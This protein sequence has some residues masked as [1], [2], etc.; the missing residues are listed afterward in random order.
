MKR[1]L[2]FSVKIYLFYEFIA[3][4]AVSALVNN[5]NLLKEMSLYLNKPV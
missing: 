4:C 2:L 5:L 3:P 1:S